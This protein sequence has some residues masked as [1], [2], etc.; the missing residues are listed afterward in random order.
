LSEG[1]VGVFFS[2]SFVGSLEKSKGGEMGVTLFAE[3]FAGVGGREGDVISRD[4]GQGS[5]GTV[6]RVPQEASGSRAKGS[7]RV[8]GAGKECMSV[9]QNCLN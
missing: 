3:A 1:F 6:G 2:P 9:C 8:E 4:S 5:F 7:S